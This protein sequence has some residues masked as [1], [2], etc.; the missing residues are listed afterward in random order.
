MQICLLR[1]RSVAFSL[2]GIPL[3]VAVAV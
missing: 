3:I 2:L 1:V